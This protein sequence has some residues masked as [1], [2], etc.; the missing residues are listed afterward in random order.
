MARMR[1]VI[2]ERVV[3]HTIGGKTRTVRVPEEKM[4]PLAP[5]DWDRV[6]LNAVTTAVA[7]MGAVSIVWSTV[8]IGHLLSLASVVWAAYLVAAIFD[9]SW[10]VCLV[11]EWLSRFN[12]EKVRAPR[13]A[14]WAALVVA[15]SA[16]F[17][18]SSLQHQPLAGLFGAAVS[19]VS[20]GLWAMRIHHTAQKLTPE[21]QAWVS[22]ELA[23]MSATAAVLGARRQMAGIN[24]RTQ[25]ILLALE[26]DTVG[27]VR[28]DVQ[29]TADTSDDV[30]TESQD[31][32]D[33]EALTGPDSVRTLSWTAG[34]SQD[35]TDTSDRVRTG[36]Q[37]TVGQRP[38]PLPSLAQL[39][40]DAMDEGVKEEGIVEA[41]HRVNPDAKPNSVIRTYRREQQ[42][43][44]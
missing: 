16:I 9:V 30:R 44:V 27:H 33:N 6:A 14:G 1:R 10:I 24:N 41:V 43:H 4:V 13:T 23:D 21:Q 8:S 38:G 18:N 37:D 36:V 31:V 5:K 35:V 7:L 29:D 40:R 20:K 25:R 2:T 39:V 12:P 26:A 28:T 15:M 34:T 42:N 22:D 3:T 11:L 32:T 17:T 19:L